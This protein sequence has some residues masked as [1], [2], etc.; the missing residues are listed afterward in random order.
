M[1]RLFFYLLLLAPFFASAQSDAALTTQSNVI[2]NEKVAS[3]NTN[4]RVANM[5]QGLIDSKYNRLDSL[6]W[7][8][9]SS[10]PLFLP[11]PSLPGVS[12]DGQSLRWNNGTGLWEYYTPGSGTVAWGD[13]TS[14]PSTI[15]GY[16]ITDFN[17]LGDARWSLKTDLSSWSTGT[18]TNDI[19]INAAGYNWAI[20]NLGTKTFSFSDGSSLEIGNTPFGLNTGPGYGN[21]IYTNDLS[22]IDLISGKGL[23]IIG[24]S[25]FLTGTTVVGTGD[26]LKLTDL[27]PSSVLTLDA[28]NNVSNS[29]VSTTALGYIGTLSSNAQTQLD[30]KQPL[31][32]DLTTIAG[33]TAT[34]DNFIQAKA[35][36]WAS[37]TVAQVKTDLGLT[38]TNSGDQTI[39]LT[40]S[41]TGSG[42]GSFATSL[43]SFT[44]N[45]LGTAIS[46]P[47]RTVTGTDAIVQADYGRTLYFNSAT[48]FNFTIDALT[49]NTFAMFRNIGT[50]TVT[51]VNGSGVTSSGAIEL[52]TGETG[53]IEYIASTTPI[54]SVSGSGGSGTPGGS[55]TQLQYNNSGA[56]A[57]I[58]GATSNGTSVTLTSPTFVTPA[59]GTPS[60][61]T[62][63]NA[64]G[65]P[66]S[67][68]VTGNL[69]V[70]NLNS[71]TS[72]SSSTFWRGDGTWATPSGSGDMVLAS[73][74]TST[75]KKTFQA[76]ATNAGLNVGS[77]AGN[78]STTINADYWYNSTS[79]YLAAKVNGSVVYPMSSGSGGSNWEIPFHFNGV[80]LTTTNSG[81]KFDAT[82][83]ST[84]MTMNRIFS[85]TVGAQTSTWNPTFRQTAGANTGMTASTAFVSSDWVG[86]TWTWTGTGTITK[87]VFNRFGAYTIS[88]STSN[89]VT[90]AFTIEILKP[91]QGSGAT[92]T[93]TNALNAEGVVIMTG[94]TITHVD[95]LTNSP[96]QNTV[97]VRNSTTGKLEGRDA[98]ALGFS[99]FNGT[100][101]G[102]GAFSATGILQASDLSD[103]ESVRI[104]LE[105][106]FTQSS[107]TA[108]A[109]A[110]GFSISCQVRKSSGTLSL[111]ATG[112]PEN[113]FNDTG[114][115]FATPAAFS[116]TAG[117]LDLTFNL[118]SSK[119]FK[120]DLWSKPFRN[121]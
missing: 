7:T 119:T 112:S 22:I 93:N 94:S 62:L 71:G 108:G 98:T 85:Q 54:I 16:G 20:N 27:A 43:G 35:G 70:T 25:T 49:I 50:A 38:G 15:A 87:Q 52:L 44:S 51:F 8:M 9:V 100:G 41:I 99:Q 65:L 76:D 75:G 36:A 4:V 26:L 55:D 32:S 63:T 13:I 1:K 30:N 109:S 57:G 95:A 48:P 40:G 91:I 118:T 116:V 5:F 80:G 117:S 84:G 21:A 11:L 28:S 88:G 2:R 46:D 29:G 68:G 111:V 66:L 72:A 106:V 105:C 102:G 6:P 33:L 59:L 113:I 97:V 120:Y 23:Q 58:S 110:F 96:T 90:N 31:D 17:S 10:K 82:S 42:T 53:L 3:R 121:N 79:N 104:N 89:T 60:S 103:G 83:N 74:Q 24:G 61:G 101:Y 39:T 14:T 78:P 114:D 69:P 115:S 67:T 73:A 37:R 56:F 12:E 47:V 86:N 34:T 81:F 45:S 107:G 77:Y 19:T 64:T 92:L 18:W